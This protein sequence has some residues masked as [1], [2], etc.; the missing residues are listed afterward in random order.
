MSTMHGGSRRDFLS[1][2]LTGA[3][4]L[5][6]GGSMGALAAAEPV[7]AE[8][9]AVGAKSKVVV[10]RDELLRGTGATVDSQRMLALLD[11]AM[12]ALF[13]GDHPAER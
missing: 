9:I 8:P 1:R 6:A 2:S 11:R 3:A 4:F 5:C 7:A 12:Q 10:A 13:G